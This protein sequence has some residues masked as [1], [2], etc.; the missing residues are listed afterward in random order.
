MPL[1]GLSREEADT[2]KKL[3]LE[4]NIR[5]SKMIEIMESQCLASAAAPE[6]PQR[7]LT[8]LKKLK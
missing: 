6:S 7:D 5:R 2:L 8:I 1:W 4:L 3:Q